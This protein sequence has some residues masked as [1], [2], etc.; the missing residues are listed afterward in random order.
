MFSKL[1]PII[2]IFIFFLSLTLA[3]SARAAITIRP[4][5]N[6]G[7][8]GYWSM[9]EGAGTTA[10]DQ[11]G[12][13]NT[14]TVY[15][16]TTPAAIWA[17]GKLGQGLSFD[18]INDYV[19]AGSGSILNI[20]GDKITLSAWVN[21]ASTPADHMGIF[22]HDSSSGGYR[23]FVEPGDVAS[24]QIMD[25]GSNPAVT[26]AITLSHNNW[27]HIVCVYDGAKLSIYIDGVKDANETSKT[28]NIPSDPSPELWIGTGDDIFPFGQW[29]YPFTGKIDEVRTYNRAL[30][31]GR[32]SG[33]TI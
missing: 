3:S 2:Y 15:S 14:G 13:R 18:G 10:N 8:V 1:K 6:L 32:S 21:Y 28:G 29:T 7:L 23:I 30:S 26:S 24:F 33:F 25:G 4:A 17:D 11:S 16:S 20:T 22:A 27:H 12:Y 9:D 19:N 31:A 5:L